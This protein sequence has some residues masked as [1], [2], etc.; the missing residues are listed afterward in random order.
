MWNKATQRLHRLCDVANVLISERFGKEMLQMTHLYYLIISYARFRV[1]SG[2][3]L[4]P[5][6]VFKNTIAKNLYLR[7]QNPPSDSKHLLNKETFTQIKIRPQL[8]K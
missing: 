1:V 8:V 7:L 5:I 6:C 2:I 4:N 3:H